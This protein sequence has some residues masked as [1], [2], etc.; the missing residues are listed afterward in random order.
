MRN[1]SS[2]AVAAFAGSAS[3]CGEGPGIVHPTL[4]LDSCHIELD[5]PL[6]AVIRLHALLAVRQ[7]CPLANSTMR[8]WAR[9]R[10]DPPNRG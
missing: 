4:P 1:V 8:S 9:S 6:P 10:V 5:A 2:R 7:A 3:V